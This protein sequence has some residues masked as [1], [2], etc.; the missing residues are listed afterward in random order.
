[1]P[2]AAPS[3]LGI[4]F[5]ISSNSADPPPQNLG[6]IKR[7]DRAG[8]YC[9]QQPAQVVSGCTQH[10]V[11]R[12][13]DRASQPTAAHS[14]ISLQVPDHRFNR[15]SAFQPAPLFLGQRFDFPPVDDF[16][17]WV[18]SVN[19]AISKIHKHLLRLFANV[20]QQNR[21]LFE[22]HGQDVP[23][24][25]VTRKG[26]C[27]NRQTASVRDRDACLHTKFVRLFGLAF[28]DALDLGRAH[29][30]ELVLAFGLL[31]AQ[32]LGALEN[33]IQSDHRRVQ[34]IQ[35]DIFRRTSRMT[36]SSTVLWRFSTRRR[37][38]NYLACA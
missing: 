1:M 34:G 15:L 37:R 9:P 26:S 12:I 27:A 18:I 38:L 35:I 11:D 20:F 4:G 23:V 13:A 5:S 17:P 16:N 3:F 36:I 28:A 19:P 30:T 10:R 14:M 8:G 29:R 22:L 21:G 31:R 2:N 24:I 25:R 6:E 32:P 33:R 7:L